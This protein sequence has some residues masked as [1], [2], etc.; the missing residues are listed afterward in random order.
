MLITMSWVTAPLAIRPENVAAIHRLTQGAGFGVGG[1]G[2]FPLVHA[3]GAAL[4]DHTFGV[5]HDAIVVRGAHRLE[6]FQTSDPSGTCAVEHD[7]DF[8]DF[9]ARNCSALS[10]P[11]AQITAVPC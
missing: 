8:V 9:L 10:R 5:A 3:F 2:G 4:I 1:M 11:A 7:F 6:Q